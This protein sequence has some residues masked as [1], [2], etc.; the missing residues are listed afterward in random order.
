MGKGKE[1][2]GRERRRRRKRKWKKS[3]K[4]EN[5]KWKAVEEMMQGEANSV[6]V[7]EEEKQRE[8]GKRFRNRTQDL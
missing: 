6:R 3:V 4:G 5:E 8:E 2:V 1:N 7:R